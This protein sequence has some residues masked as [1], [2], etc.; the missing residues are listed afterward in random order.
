MLS[1]KHDI[2][3]S[4]ELEYLIMIDFFLLTIEK[5]IGIIIN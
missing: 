2:M 1:E 3:N 5:C 4:A